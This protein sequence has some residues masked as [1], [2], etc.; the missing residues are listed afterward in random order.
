[1]QVTQL[2]LNHCDAAQQLL[3]Q[4]VAEWGTD[5]AII[6]DP[7]RVPAGNGNWV[8]D[9]SKMAAIWTTGKYPVQELV[10]STHEGF[11]IA[12]VN[13]VFF[14]SCYAPPRWS[15]EQFGRML[16]CLTADLMGRRPVV[17]AGD[18]NAWAV[19]WG[20]RSTNQ[21][22][23]ILLESLAMLDVDLANVGTKSTYSWNGAE[24][25]ID[26]IERLS[27]II[28]YRALAERVVRTGG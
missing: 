13:G 19:E 9:G 23:Q 1:M 4:T 3:C 8:T 25:I 15:I 5:I 10:S 20:S 24:S 17:I 28:D 21:R 16:D 14:C 22:G 7:Y 6:A 26:V 11:V 2:N 12:K 27:T 18:F